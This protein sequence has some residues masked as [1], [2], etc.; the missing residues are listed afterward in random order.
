MNLLARITNIVES[1]EYVTVL[2][3]VSDGNRDISSDKVSIRRSRLRGFKKS[4]VVR[5]IMKV[6]KTYEAYGVQT[7]DAALRSLISRQISYDPDSDSLYRINLDFYGAT[8][9][10]YGIG[11]YSVSNSPATLSIRK[12]TCGS[13]TLA[14]GSDYMWAEIERGMGEVE[15]VTFQLSGG[16]ADLDIHQQG[17]GIVRVIV[18]DQ[19]G[20]MDVQE[21]SLRWVE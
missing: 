7:S 13:G 18:G 19:E 15:N 17:K 3:T 11:E 9:G 12:V 1:D 16:V 14:G 20:N 8:I 2:F 6:L 10:D 21:V 5:E 4:R